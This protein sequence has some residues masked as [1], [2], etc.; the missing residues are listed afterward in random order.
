MLPASFLSR[1][2]LTALQTFIKLCQDNINAGIVLDDARELQKVA[3][4]FLQAALK[5]IR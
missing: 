3:D 2:L 4:T 1:Q 5:R